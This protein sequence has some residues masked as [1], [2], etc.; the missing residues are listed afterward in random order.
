MARRPIASLLEPL[1]VVSLCSYAACPTNAQV[2]ASV[3]SQT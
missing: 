2:P 3:R 1:I